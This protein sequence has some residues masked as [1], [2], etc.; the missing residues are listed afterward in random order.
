VEGG[1]W[2]WEAL[3]GMLKMATKD[4]DLLEIWAPIKCWDV[5]TNKGRNFI[6]CDGGVHFLNITR[7]VE[8]LEWQILPLR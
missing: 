2:A 1:L 4:P 6:V 5:Y 3:Q 7:P 8:S